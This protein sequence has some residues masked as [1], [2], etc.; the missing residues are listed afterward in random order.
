MYCAPVVLPVLH[1][2]STF[3]GAI[4]DLAAMDPSA[5]STEAVRAVVAAAGGSWRDILRWVA[6]PGFLIAMALALALP[7]P[8]EAK[9]SGGMTSGSGGTVGGSGGMTSSSGGITS[10]SS[11]ITSGSGGGGGGVEVLRGRLQDGASQT[12]SQQGDV[13][14]ASA[15]HS[16]TSARTMSQQGHGSAVK[17]Q[18]GRRHR[19][20]RTSRTLY[21]TS[22]N[23]A[24][25]AQAQGLGAAAHT[26]SESASTGTS[27]P[28]P[29]S[30]PSAQNSNGGFVALLKTPA[31]LFTTLAASFNDVGSYALVAWQS[32]FYERIHHLEPSQYAPVLA[33]VL[34][35]GGIVGGVGGGWLADFVARGEVNHDPADAMAGAAVTGAAAGA[36]AAE[37]GAATGLQTRTWGK[38]AGRGEVSRRAWVTV[39]AS[40][41]AAPALLVS[42]TMPDHAQSYLA[43]LVGFALS[44][45][46]RAPAANMAR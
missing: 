22:G 6:L 44:E 35:L 34:P 41:A 11:G 45:A 37:G 5:V 42:M 16:Q 17:Q 23:E 7:E 13:Q 19:R 27:P 29:A 18:H 14:A 2:Y 26:L 32:T 10:G 39:G 4:E 12:G 1:S 9:A 25:Q 3:S 38:A 24:G 43:L 28:V 30:T 21:G 8:R 36:G 20:S 15:A 46:W 33:A 31:F 40:L